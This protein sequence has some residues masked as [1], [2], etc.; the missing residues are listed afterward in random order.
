M[1]KKAVLKTASRIM[2]ISIFTFLILFN[3][4]FFAPPGYAEDNIFTDN[5]GIG[6]ANPSEV[7]DVNGNLIMSGGDIKTDRWLSS[8]QLSSDKVAC[9][10]EIRFTSPPYSLNWRQFFKK[11]GYLI[12]CGRHI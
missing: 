4:F 6:T 5:V 9:A 2:P 3:F 10:I 11:P 8:A 1:F 12:I 7:L